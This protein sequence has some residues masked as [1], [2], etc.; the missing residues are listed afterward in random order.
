MDCIFCKIVKGEIPSLRVYEDE[1]S[2][3]ILD[4]NPANYG[5][6]LVLPKE[7]HENVFDVPE[8]T[9][10]HLAAVAK[11]IATRIKSKLGADG[12]N[13]LQNN[14]KA[15]GQ[16][17]MHM[18][19]HVIP[20]YENDKVVITYE[21]VQPQPEK[22]KEMLETLSSDAEPEPAPEPD[23]PEEKFSI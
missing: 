10:K 18:H 5:H 21:R 13:I 2:L 9:I 19:I 22:M 11:K 3:A 17:V 8:E 4:I 7:H 1:K 14:G 20:R 16:I 15:A 12:V 6:T 23:N